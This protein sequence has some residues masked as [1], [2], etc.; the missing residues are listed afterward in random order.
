[1]LAQNNN[2]IF[3]VLL[4]LLLAPFSFIT[5]DDMKDIAYKNTCTQ[6]FEE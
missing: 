1:M 3:V 5:Y 6:Y 4:L 2:G